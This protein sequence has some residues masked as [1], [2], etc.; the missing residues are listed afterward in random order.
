M[1]NWWVHVWAV[2]S[3]FC[4]HLTSL[5]SHLAIDVYPS[6]KR[7]R[8]DKTKA[9]SEK[10]SIMTNNTSHTSFPMS[11]RWTAYVAPNPQRGPPI[12]QQFFRFPYRK[13]AF[14][15]RKSATKFLCVKIFSG[16]VVR[17]SL[18]YPYTNGWW[19]MSRCIWNFGSKSPAP[20]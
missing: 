4:A 9:P 10:S 19:G 6:V 15:R 16:K 20:F 12:R 18:A 13:L 5:D 1:L 2:K 3:H 11:L 17:H 14:P 7:V 8:C